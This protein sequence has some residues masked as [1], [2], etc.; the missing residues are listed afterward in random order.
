MLTPSACSG[1][2]PPHTPPPANLTAK[3][4]A[5]APFT[6]ATADD[7]VTDYLDLIGLYRDCSVRHNA[8]IDAL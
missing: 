2:P 3:C 8:L 5:P 7:L 4:P 6:G 1:P